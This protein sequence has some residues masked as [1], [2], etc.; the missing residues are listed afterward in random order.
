MNKSQYERLKAYELYL[1]TAYYSSYIKC[2]TASEMKELESIYR[3]LGYKLHNK[4]CGECILSMCKRLGNLYFTY[5]LN[6]ETNGKEGKRKKT[7]TQKT[8]S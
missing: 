7:S 6:Q 2:L 4:H 3:E 8:E 5:Q 1:H